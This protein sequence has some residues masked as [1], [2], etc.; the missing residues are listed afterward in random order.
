MDDVKI[1]V[2]N[3]KSTFYVY[4]DRWFISGVEYNKLFN[5]N[6]LIYRHAKDINRFESFVDNIFS[7]F[8]ITP[9][10]SGSIIN[11]TYRFDSDNTNKELVPV[12]H[13]IEIINATGLIYQYEVRRL[14]CDIETT[15][16]FESPQSFGLNMKVE[17]DGNPY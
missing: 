6:K 10:Y 14:K 13:E 16:D 1:R 11:E 15:K 2:D 12:T 17:W 8:R 9:Y 4:D 3:D 5:G 7:I